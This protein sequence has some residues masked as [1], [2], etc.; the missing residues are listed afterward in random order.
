MLLV[1]SRV[2]SGAG[3]GVVVSMQSS[4]KNFRR[5]FFKLYIL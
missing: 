3:V 1:R 4:T 5:G 2:S